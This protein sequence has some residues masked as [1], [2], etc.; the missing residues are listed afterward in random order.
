[1]RAPHV[2]V[3]VS[4]LHLFGAASAGAATLTYESTEPA[5]AVYVN[6]R[7]IRPDGTNAGA[8]TQTFRLP[9][10]GWSKLEIG[11]PPQQTYL[12]DLRAAL[13]LRGSSEWAIRTSRQFEGTRCLIAE[14]SSVPG[15]WGLCEGD[16]VI[17]TRTVF[18]IDRCFAAAVAAGNPRVRLWG[19]DG[20]V[21]ASD[22]IITSS[23]G[24]YRARWNKGRIE[25]SF[26]RNFSCED[27]PKASTIS[28]PVSVVEVT[29]HVAIGLARR[30]V[31]D[32]NPAVNQCH[33][34][35]RAEGGADDAVPLRVRLGLYPSG[36]VSRMTTD[37]TLKDKAFIRC[38]EQALSTLTFPRQ[39]EGDRPATV[40]VMIKSR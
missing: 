31:T 7:R 37:G 6:G 2:A 35:P 26:E 11:S 21:Y 9:D 4:V 40:T 27:A 22:M 13:E 16:E 17:P 1:M 3:I 18:Q 33:R 36:R 30:V 23:P 39:T 10:A 15:Y 5:P 32:A 14:P 34:A 8:Y 29:G 20:T 19:L 25:V 28:S 12:V 38:V 24:L